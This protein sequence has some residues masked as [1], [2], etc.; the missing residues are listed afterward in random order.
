MAAMTAK[1]V[2]TRTYVTPGRVITAMNKLGLKTEGKQ[3][4]RFVIDKT[5]DGRYFPVFV[6][7]KEAMVKADAG[8]E[9]TTTRRRAAAK[10]TT[11]AV[12]KKAPRKRSTRK[13]DTLH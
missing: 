12:A 8:E 2:P 9:Q 11:K 3:A 7:G 6:G 4:V 5:T 1:Q 10:K 13:K